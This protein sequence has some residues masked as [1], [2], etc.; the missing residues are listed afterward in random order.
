MPDWVAQVLSSFLLSSQQQ[1]RQ[2]LSECL[3]SII[4]LFII[5][6]PTLE[7]FLSDLKPVCSDSVGNNLNI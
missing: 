4:Y 3:S 2:Q 5:F 6:L 1:L 7:N